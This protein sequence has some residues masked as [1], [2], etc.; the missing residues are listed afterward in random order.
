MI[1]PCQNSL[2]IGGFGYIRPQWPINHD[3]LQSKGARGVNLCHRAASTGILGDDMGDAMLLHQRNIFGHVERASR[4]GDM[5]VG[6][7]NLGLRGVNEPQQ[8]VVFGARREQVHMHP[9]N[10]QKDAARIRGQSITGTRDI[11]HMNPIIIRLRAPC[12]SRQTQQRR[13]LCATCAIG[14]LPHR[15]CKRMR[16]VNNVADPF[17]LQVGRQTICPAKTAYSHV[18]GLRY[19]RVC[20]AGIRKN[21]LYSG[22]MKSLRQLAGL[23]GPAQQ[24]DAHDG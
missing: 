18:N 4:N 12:R 9:A 14:V 3:N 19:R 21:S 17:A 2:Y 1:K 13:A 15:V 24:K 5:V 16:S 7:G 23:C 11:R 8:V 22:G 20:A 10:R 6:Q